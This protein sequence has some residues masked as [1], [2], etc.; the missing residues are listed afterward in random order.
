MEDQTYTREDNG[1][2]IPI[3][4]HKRN[5]DNN[6]ALLQVK[7][8]SLPSIRPNTSAS[9][10]ETAAGATV[11]LY[12]YPLGTEMPVAKPEMSR[13]AL[14]QSDDTMRIDKQISPG[15]IGGPLLI[16]NGSAIGVVLSAQYV[17][18]MRTAVKIFKVVG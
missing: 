10:P 2:K 9:G 15:E 17:V 5:S 4:I 18:P 13:T 11:M 1:E 3:R 16:Q 7:D 6:L 14:V 12:G 8:A